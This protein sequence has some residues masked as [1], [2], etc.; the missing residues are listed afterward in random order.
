MIWGGVKYSLLR[1]WFEVSSQRFKI[2]GFDLFSNVDDLDVGRGVSI[3]VANHLTTSVNIINI[4][5]VNREV[6]WLQMKSGINSKVSLGCIYRRL[7]NTS[8]D[9]VKLHS[10]L[11]KL[12]KQNTFAIIIMGDFNHSNVNCESVTTEKN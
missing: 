8:D 3:Y 10:F 11:A 9:D 7:S 12:S 4:G 5:I 6:I 1:L 2:E